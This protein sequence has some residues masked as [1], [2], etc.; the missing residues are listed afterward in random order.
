MNPPLYGYS[1][2]SSR[3]ERQWEEKTS[4]HPQPRQYARIHA[5]PLRPPRTTLA[6]P[7]TRDNTDWLAAKFKEFGFENTKLNPTTSSF[8]LPKNANSN[9]STAKGHLNHRLLPEIHRENLKSPRLPSI[10]NLRPRN[11]NS[12]PPTTP[13]RKTATSSPRSSTSNYGIPE[14]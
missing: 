4:R 3:A 2:E 7:T 1:A 11:P 5:P 8:Q 12:C 6:R 9:S 10:S 13:I 14:D